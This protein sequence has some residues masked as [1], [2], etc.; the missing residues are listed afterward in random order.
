MPWPLLDIT[1]RSTIKK[2]LHAVGTT[3]AAVI[4]VKI[5]YSSSD[6]SVLLVWARPFLIFPVCLI[7]F[8]VY[9]SDVHTLKTG[10]NLFNILFC[11][12]LLLAATLSCTQ[13]KRL[14]QKSELTDKTKELYYSVP[15]GLKYADVDEFYRKGS[16]FLII[17]PNS[18][19]ILLQDPDS[20]P[21]TVGEM[22]DRLEEFARGVSPEKR[23]AFIAA[24]FDITP[25]AF[26]NVLKEIRRRGIERVVLLVSGRDTTEG[27]GP[28][29]YAP[30]IPFPERS[31]TAN[32][33]AEV[34]FTEQSPKPN[35]FTLVVRVV[36]GKPLINAEPVEDLDELTRRLKAV[37]D[38]RENNGVFRES[39][40]EVEK[41][42]NVHIDET[43]SNSGQRYGGI[44][45]IINAV[46]GA[47]SNRIVLLGSEPAIL[48]VPQI[49]TVGSR[50]LPSPGSGSLP[51]T[52]SG[53][54]INGKATSLP[55]PGY[56]PAA[57][58]VRASRSVSVEVLVDPSGNVTSANAVSG[59]PLLR[60]SAVQAA[61]AAKF[62]P[63]MLSG[64]PVSV[65]GILTYN[66]V[67]E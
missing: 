15:A 65:K 32:L 5:I 34:D 22:G 47:G 26:L 49:K 17:L 8:R 41:T 14:T 54:V 62:A 11:S 28:I 7:A 35:P 23:E 57:R 2:N 66:F 39:T 63:T 19:E 29:K 50:P 46:R 58:A 38:D 55:K 6:R 16:S 33:A 48:G 40:N 53:G 42:V 24:A 10:R 12:L 37:L 20:A 1:A 51:K 3:D 13:F 64:Q 36:N 43:G 31:F 45:E 4:D 18:D 30:D 52:I 44:V 9:N 59:H 25:E 56:P 61:R 21:I 27:P 60:A 67:A